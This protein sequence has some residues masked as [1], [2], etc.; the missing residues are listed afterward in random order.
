MSHTWQTD[1]GLQGWSEGNGVYLDLFLRHVI[2]LH[3]KDT[4][5]ADSK[6]GRSIVPARDK[7]VRDPAGSATG[8]RQPRLRI[9]H[10]MD[11]NA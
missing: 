2:S 4:W 8:R 10:M 11:P 7:I 9:E 3:D 6:C 1:H 5:W